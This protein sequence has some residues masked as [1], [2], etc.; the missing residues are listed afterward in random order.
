MT[1]K[2]SFPFFW[3]VRLS[4]KRKLWDVGGG[5]EM[6]SIL[7][8]EKVQVEKQNKTKKILGTVGMSDLGERHLIPGI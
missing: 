1:L 3:L 6:R 4:R 7:T 5:G 8:L 2:V